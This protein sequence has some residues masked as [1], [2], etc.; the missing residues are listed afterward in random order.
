V[1]LPL[2]ANTVGINLIEVGSGLSIPIA[3]CGTGVEQ[4]LVLIAC[5]LGAKDKRLFLLDEPQDFLHPFLERH[6]MEII[7]SSSHSFMIA[8]HSATIINSVTAEQITYLEKPGKGFNEY[9]NGDVNAAEILRQLGYKNSDFLFFDGVLFV[10]GMSDKELLPMLFA[11]A[12]PSDWK[13]LRDIGTSDLGGTRDYQKFDDMEDDVVRQEKIMKALHRTG[14]PHIYLFD[15]DK[16][17]S[18]GRIGDLRPTGTQLKYEFL[19]RSEL[20]NYLL[21]SSAIA[22]AINEERKERNIE[23]RVEI[24]GVESALQELLSSYDGGDPKISK[25]LYKVQPQRG[26][27]HLQVQGSRLLEKLYERFE[28]R[29]DKRRAGARIIAHLSLD[30]TGTDEL[31]KTLKSLITVLT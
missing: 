26:M 13:M 17:V 16:R 27:E 24:S 22:S 9:A 7:D 30:K 23:E 2:T 12:S 8:T 15:G 18:A 31:T 21:D 25:F 5:I 19:E 3:Q 28:M 6:L 1:T 10:E 20:E 29:Y 11:K 4:I 14:L